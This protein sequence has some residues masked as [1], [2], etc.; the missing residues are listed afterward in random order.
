ATP[1]H[2][3]AKRGMTVLRGGCPNVLLRRACHSSQS[4]PKFRGPPTSNDR[5]VASRPAAFRRSGLD[6]FSSVEAASVV[7][8][9]AIDDCTILQVA[10][11]S[12]SGTRVRRLAST[13]RAIPGLRSARADKQVEVRA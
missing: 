2:F 10:F 13:A 3:S 6:R 8:E 5:R 4:P 11:L 9:L 1:R 7:T 12:T